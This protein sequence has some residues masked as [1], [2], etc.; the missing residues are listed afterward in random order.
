MRNY[1]YEDFD[2]KPMIESLFWMFFIIQANAQIWYNNLNINYVKPIFLYVEKFL[3]LNEEDVTHDTA[4]SLIY[5]DYKFISC[6]LHCNDENKEKQKL[7][8]TLNE[9]DYY[10]GNK[11]FTNDWV[12][13]YCQSNNIDMPSNYSICFI[14]N[15]IN[16]IKIDLEQYIILDK[17]NYIIKTI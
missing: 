16:T 17:N 11:L 15:N 5:T 1:Q 3:N 4:E 13:N 8:I 14:D 7:S 6:E 10:V 9:Y 2:I 12:K